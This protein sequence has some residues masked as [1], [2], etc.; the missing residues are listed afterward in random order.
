M[1]EITVVRVLLNIGVIWNVTA[2][3]NEIT[4]VRFL[5][6]IGCVWNVTGRE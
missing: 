4:D 6:N 5:L 2:H 3:M 1:N